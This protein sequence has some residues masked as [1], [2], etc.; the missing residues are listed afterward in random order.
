MNWRPFNLR[1]ILVEQNN[2]AFTKDPVRMDYV[3]RDI[4]R[5]SR[6]HGLEYRSRPPYPVDPD[7]LALR[8]GLVAAGEDWCPAYSKATFR[9]W[10]A[11]HKVPGVENNVREILT[12]LGQP[13]DRTLAI[14]ASEE[15]T[16]RLKAQTKSARDRGIFSAPNFVVGDE[17][18]W[19]DDRLEEAIAY[20]SQP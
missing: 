14:A 17:L 2:I 8:V 7:L 15:V 11:E 4:E 9:A 10:F 1:E 5:R 3:W 19:G 13:V 20:A 12:A 6:Q 18:F 16:E